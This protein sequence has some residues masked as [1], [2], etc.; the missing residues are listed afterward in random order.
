MPDMEANAAGL[1]WRLK[2]VQDPA[3]S[4]AAAG[5]SL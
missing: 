3:G 5:A 2:A 4:W 1:Y